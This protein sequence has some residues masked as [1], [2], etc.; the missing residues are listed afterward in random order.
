[1]K[2]SCKYFII[3]GVFGLI[4]L[5]LSRPWTY[6]L[7]QISFTEA[8]LF[9]S[10]LTAIS[11][12]GA[13]IAAIFAAY[14]AFKTWRLEKE[15]IVHAMGTFIIS[16]SVKTNADRDNFINR[17]DSLHTLH[18]VNVGRG[19]AKNI[20]PST[21][22]TKELQG[23]FLEEINPHS[24]SLPSNQ[25]TRVFKETLRVHG[26]RFTQKN[27]YKLE[28]IDNNRIAFFYLHYE[29]HA[30]KLY[31]TKVKIQRV[32]QV[33]DQNLDKLIKDNKG[34]EVWKVMENIDESN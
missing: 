12:T 20:M 13:L 18:L 21:G 33:D 10:M 26:T 2:I 19:S 7:L 27:P 34:I 5:L 14:F 15:P 1:M 24:F 8:N 3:G 28:F 31:L 29:D 4:L 17:K 9:W 6:P 25:G 32:E 23:K 22:K 11:T 30:G 16:T